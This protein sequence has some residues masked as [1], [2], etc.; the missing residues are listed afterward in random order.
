MNDLDQ[1]KLQLQELTR[2]VVQMNELLKG[3]TDN[4][5]DLLALKPT[6][7]KKGSPS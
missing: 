1:I 4:I 2:L 3:M 7:F 5:P 6:Q